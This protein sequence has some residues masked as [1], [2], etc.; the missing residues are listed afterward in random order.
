MARTCLIYDSKCK[1]HTDSGNWPC[2]ALHNFMRPYNLLVWFGRLTFIWRLFKVGSSGL[3]GW[4]PNEYVKW[5]NQIE[6]N[7]VQWIRYETCNCSINL[8]PCRV[9]PNYDPLLGGSNY[10]GKPVYSLRYEFFFSV[11]SEGNMMN[12]SNC[13]F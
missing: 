5:H 1:M 6:K 9:L 3:G 7:T 10:F 2:M 13:L 11:W 12:S 8:W 4:I